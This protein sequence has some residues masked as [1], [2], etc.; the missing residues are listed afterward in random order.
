MQLQTFVD[1]ALP[2]YTLQVE[3]NYDTY[4]SHAVAICKHRAEQMS[5]RV[6]LLGRLH[7][8]L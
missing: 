4:P 8:A 6:K 1:K 5:C 2:K 3:N 7:L